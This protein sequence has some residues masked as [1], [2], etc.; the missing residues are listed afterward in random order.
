[1]K[2][3]RL[4]GRLVGAAHF[5]VL[6]MIALYSVLSLTAGSEPAALNGAGKTNLCPGNNESIES[7]K[8]KEYLE[9]IEAIIREHASFNGLSLRLE[10]ELAVKAPVSD[11]NL[12]DRGEHSAIS[13][14]GIASWYGGS[15][16]LDGAVTASGEIFNAT[17]FTAA[18]P[19]LPFGSRVKVTYR[20]TGR[21]VVVRIN[22]R[23]PF[24]PGRIID[25]SRA[26]AAEIGLL[27]HG[28]GVVD[29]E[30]LD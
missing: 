21:S 1:M 26:A 13:L 23:G 15:D 5:C 8:V 18:H 29:L 2:G 28:I 30:L 6:S 25:L 20:V 4:S 22:D 16:G 19:T 17:S 11:R 3:L 9:S 12:P 27:A 24:V 14:S 7:L 10:C